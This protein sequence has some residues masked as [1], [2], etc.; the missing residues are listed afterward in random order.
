M[1]TCGSKKARNQIITS[2]DPSNFSLGKGSWNQKKARLDQFL[3]NL[4]DNQYLH[5]EFRENKVL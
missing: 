4:T 5:Q 3:S 2:I 1:T